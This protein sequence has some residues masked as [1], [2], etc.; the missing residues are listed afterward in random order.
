MSFLTAE[1]MRAMDERAITSGIS[2]LALMGRAARGLAVEFLS[3]CGGDPG[4]VL[5]LCGAGN[6]GGDGFAL[7]YLL[8]FHVRDVEVW[9]A[10]EPQRIQGDAKY[11]L[12]QLEE[13]RIPVSFLGDP[14]DWD[15]DAAERPMV[16]WVV[17]SLLGTGS[18]GTPDGAVAAAVSLVEQLAEE[19]R[20]LSVDLPTGLNP[21]TGTPFEESI[22]VRAD[23]TFTLG[24]AKAGF[25]ADGSAAWTGSV[26]IV[27]LGFSTEML[28]E[29]SVEKVGVMDPL[30]AR[31]WAPGRRPVHA[32]KSTFGHVLV[33]GGSPGMVGAPILTGRAALRRGAGMVSVLVPRCC[34]PVAASMFPELMV[35]A[36]WEDEE[37]CLMD[38]EIAFAEY[39][40][41]VIGPGM[42]VTGSTRELVDRTCMRSP[43]PVVLDAGALRALSGRLGFLQDARAPR[44]LTPH[45]GEMAGLLGIETQAVLADRRA[46][47]ERAVNLSSSV[48]ILK[49][50]H[51]WV[52]GPEEDCWLNLNGN[53]G[54]ATAGSGDILAGILAA[55]IAGKCL[56]PIQSAVLACFEHGRAGDRAAE[57][58]GQAGM[59]AGDLLETLPTLP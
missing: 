58:K 46:A 17:D 8:G 44:I 23:V 35:Y 12:Q 25:L 52:G 29:A 15:L 1:A 53:P 33:I 3:L 54:M 6:N 34:A 32:H 45:P 11:Y 42:R 5:I 27:D 9:V 31:K 43:V 48:V 55:H 47:L 39:D 16:D 36:G 51:S 40:A 19:A 57:Q 30:T 21:D 20:V 49:G 59:T 50:C 37:G 13:A 7:A 18:R 56:S 38:Q 24:A 2:G 10:A 26:T 28:Q 41:I 14:Q 22:C 4:R